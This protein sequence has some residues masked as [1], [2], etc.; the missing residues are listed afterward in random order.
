MKE[1][2]AQISEQVDHELRIPKRADYDKQNA[3]ELFEQT[4][5][6]ALN[7]IKP[8]TLVLMVDEFNTLQDKIDQNKIN[9]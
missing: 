4:I 2:R 6:D 7:I 8:K 9:E 5:E 1:I 3:F